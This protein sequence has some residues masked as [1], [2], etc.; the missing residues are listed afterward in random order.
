ME[1]EIYGFAQKIAGGIVVD[2]ETLARE[3]IQ[4][5]GPGGTYLGQKHTRQHMAEIWQPTVF[6]RSPYDMWVRGGKAG[7][8]EKAREIAVGIL[9]SHKPEPLPADAAAELRAMVERAEAG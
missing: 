3:V 7:A 4:A 8:Y 5:V 9:D 6:D 2:T 1:S